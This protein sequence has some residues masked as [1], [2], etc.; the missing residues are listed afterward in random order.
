MCR[1]TP[2]EASGL[3]ILNRFEKNLK[4]FLDKLRSILLTASGMTRL[5]QDY[6]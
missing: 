3:K 2:D 4:A 5:C 1:D 6:P